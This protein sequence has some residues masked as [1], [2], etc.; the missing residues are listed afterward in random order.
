MGEAKAVRGENVMKA[1]DLKQFHGSNHGARSHLV[2]FAIMLDHR[3]AGANRSLNCVW[4]S[5]RV[6]HAKGSDRWQVPDSNV[7]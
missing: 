1:S 4:S 6:R 5:E 7:T 2:R 3:Q